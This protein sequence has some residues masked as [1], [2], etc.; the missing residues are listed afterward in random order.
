MKGKY[1]REKIFDRHDSVDG[2]FIG[3]RDFARVKNFSS[4]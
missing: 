2:F 1:P 4:T 3:N